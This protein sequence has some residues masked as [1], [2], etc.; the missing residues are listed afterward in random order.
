M[1]DVANPVRGR[2][3]YDPASGLAL[4]VLGGPELFGRTMMRRGPFAI[5]G[6]F[7]GRP[8]TLLDCYPR[9]EKTR[10]DVTEGGFLVSQAVFG[11]H[12]RD[13]T[14]VSC[15]AV[16]VSY[17]ELDEWVAPLSPLIH[18]TRPPDSNDQLMV[19][20]V[21]DDDRYVAV[22]H[23]AEVRLAF[24]TVATQTHTSA[25]VENHA[26]FVVTP[27]APATADGMMRDY[28]R[29]LENFVTFATGR[30][31]VARSVEFIQLAD[32]DERP[33][34]LLYWP[35]QRKNPQ[36]QWWP[37]FEGRGLFSLLDISDSFSRCVSSWLDISRQYKTVCD[38]LFGT[39]YNSRQFLETRFV[40][41][42]QAAEGFHRQTDDMT[43][44]RMPR[45]EFRAIRKQA[46]RSIPLEL[47]AKVDLALQHALQRAN[48]VSLRMRLDELSQRFGPLIP[49]VW[50]P[51]ERE[52][53]GDHCAKARNA[54][55]HHVP[56]PQW[57]EPFKLNRY[58]DYILQLLGVALM[59]SLGFD[60][61]KIEHLMRRGPTLVKE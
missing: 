15:N 9:G 60:D 16:R 41:L 43:Q 38:L 58:N 18:V 55:A 17:T 48:D 25:S 14:D 50:E 10:G 34:E 53:F 57:T 28:I 49:G 45:N 12:V 24:V 35:I 2:F 40:A 19:S 5:E 26:E 36:S 32:H 39:I 20:L 44:Y 7:E 61:T 51:G 13:L 30:T 59:R 21:K 4:R 22:H 46:C 29:P 54:F 47:R 11:C 8:V 27:R 23:D 42:V 1:R 3:T 31:N 52:S 56:K 6:T 33:V 37:H